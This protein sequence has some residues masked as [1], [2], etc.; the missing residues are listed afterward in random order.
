MEAFVK[1]NDAYALR[2]I[3]INRWESPV[4]KQYGIQALPHLILYED[5]K[6]IAEGRRNVIE[7]LNE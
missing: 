2:K 3:D 6:R 7:A 1:K 4:A 5:G